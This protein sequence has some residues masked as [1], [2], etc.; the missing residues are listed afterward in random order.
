[1]WDQDHKCVRWG[2]VA[3]GRASV[4]KKYLSS[5][6]LEFAR[7]SL[8]FPEAA[9]LLVNTKNRDLWEKPEGEPAVVRFKFLTR[10]FY[11]LGKSTVCERSVPSV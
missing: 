6:E 2:E 8:L 11:I 3:G 10:A 7:F 5:E 4:V 9:K 1:M